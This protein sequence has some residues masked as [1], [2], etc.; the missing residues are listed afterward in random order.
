M[1]PP[2]HPSSGSMMKQATTLIAFLLLVVFLL[3]TSS[4]APSSPIEV[5]RITKSQTPEPAQTSSKVA[6]STTQPTQTDVTTQLS[7]E[8]PSS[9]PT[10][11]ATKL[12]SP[13]AIPS[14]TATPTIPPINLAGTNLE[15]LAEGQFEQLESSHITTKD[16]SDYL[17]YTLLDTRL[18]PSDVDRIAGPEACRVA[19]FRS[20]DDE[21]TFLGS[22][23]APAYSQPDNYDF[24]FTCHL[25]DWEE[26][27]A[28]APYLSLDTLWPAYHSEKSK[29]YLHLKSASSDINGNGFPE[30]AVVYQYCFSICW[31]YGIVATHFYEVRTESVVDI[32]L[33]IPGVIDPYEN[34]LH[35]DQAGTIYVYDRGYVG[36]GSIVDTWWIYAWNG[37]EYED[38][39]SQFANDILEWGEDRL[40]E[41][42]LEY[43]K[44]LRRYGYDF[45]EILLQFDK[46]GLRDEAIEIIVELSDLS[47]WPATD[48]YFL[49]YLQI[50]REN[51]LMEYRNNKP[52]SLPPGVLGFGSMGL[53]EECKGLNAE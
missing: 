16:G 18:R 7:S 20:E 36:P 53:P 38:V 25:I 32:T 39:T 23:P 4:C 12:D 11:A 44:P 9:T 1:E 45:S 30:F 42:R 33:N 47:H 15:D 34:L 8:M 13:T 52:F 49:C 2:I 10:P 24:P 5:S 51:A 35:D 37:K 28:I 26:S 46:A 3:F 50:I 41:I 31:D 14:P 40:Q 27:S 19:F 17:A 43:G 48:E 29:E 22:L 6:A 21:N